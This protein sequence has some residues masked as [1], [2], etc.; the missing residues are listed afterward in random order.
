MISEKGGDFVEQLGKLKIK[1]NEIF[2]E[3][4]AK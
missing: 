3:I 2:Y 4:Q 1:T